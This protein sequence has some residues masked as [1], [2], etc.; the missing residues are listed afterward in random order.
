VRKLQYLKMLV[1]FST[2]TYAKP[3]CGRASFIPI[4]ALFL[5]TPA[6]LVSTEVAAVFAKLLRLTDYAQNSTDLKFFENMLLYFVTKFRWKLR[7]FD[8]FA[9]ALEKMSSL[10]RELKFGAGS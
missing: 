6:L 8:G 5:S 2:R 3:T 1:F 7:E 9:H 10:E 4:E